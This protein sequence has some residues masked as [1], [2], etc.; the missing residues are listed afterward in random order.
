[1]RQEFRLKIGKEDEFLS[2]FF[3]TFEV[4]FIFSGY[5]GRAKI[6]SSLKSNHQAL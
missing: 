1:V 3:T 4:S 5:W 2:N 6:G